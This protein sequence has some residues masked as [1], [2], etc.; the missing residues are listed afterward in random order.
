LLCES[1]SAFPRAYHTLEHIDKC[2]DALPELAPNQPDEFLDPIR[3]AI[4]FHDACM[5]FGGPGKDEEDS[6]DL[7]CDI[8]A[9]VGIP[10]GA[11]R[12]LILA[13]KTHV[14]TLPD[15]ALLLDADLSI[16]AAPSDIFWRYEG[17]V[18]QE[19]AHVPDEIYR[20]ARRRILQSFRDR[21]QIYQS[22]HGFHEWE[23]KAR[24]NLGQ[25]IAGLG[26][27]D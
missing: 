19:Y 2:L 7:A 5:S 3:W 13:T 15:E 1:Y 17:Q 26:G 24:F 23:R 22:P 11:T 14:A 12:R 6:A 21:R 25:S 16:L 10:H 4:W 20:P 18:R 9:E 27:V 8:A